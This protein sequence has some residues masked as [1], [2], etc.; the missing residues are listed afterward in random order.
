MD[1]TQI[2]EELNGPRD[3]GGGT[4]G[5]AGR[6]ISA[7]ML[8]T[9]GAN[10]DAPWKCEQVSVDMMCKECKGRTVIRAGER[11]V[12]DWWMERW[13]CMLCAEE[14]VL[15]GRSHRAKTE[16][17]QFV[18]D[19]MRLAW[20]RFAIDRGLNRIAYV[21]G[22]NDITH[23][24]YTD[25]SAGGEFNPENMDEYGLWEYYAG[26]DLEGR[27][28]EDAELDK[29]HAEFWMHG[30]WEGVAP[31]DKSEWPSG[32]WS[33]DCLSVPDEVYIKDGAL[34]LGYF[35]AG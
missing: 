1:W 3:F 16:Y 14:R 24:E 19:E 7:L 23:W 6:A 10:K 29:R 33:E 9:S 12:W 32:P 2:V 20:R 17:E 21:D 13:I 15:G 34:Y 27:E 31:I 5:A 35:Q 25:G 26:A 30:E 11:A 22:P 8:E 28:D 18:Y 4:V